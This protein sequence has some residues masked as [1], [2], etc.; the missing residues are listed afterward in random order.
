MSSTTVLGY[1][2]DRRPIEL[3]KLRNSH[4][5]APSIWDRMLKARG[6]EGYMFSGTVLDDLWQ[7]IET[8]PEWEQ[9]PL[10][11]TFDTGIVPFQRYT[12]CADAL[13]E[14][15]RRLPAPAG[16]VNHV[17]A[18]AELLRSQPETPW[19]GVWGTSVS[20]NPFDPWDE[21]ADAEGNGIPITD[22]YVL[23]QHRRHLPEPGGSL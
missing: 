1:V 19:V 15:E 22:C 20:E 9:V 6:H 10:V 2:P 5:W 11:L 17:P 8:L 12:E 18:V 3:V 16:Q 14:F 13:D 23:E 7:S 4:G 21:E